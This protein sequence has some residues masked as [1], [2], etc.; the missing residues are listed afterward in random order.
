MSAGFQLSSMGEAFPKDGSW[1]CGLLVNMKSWKV[2]W[3]PAV[4][5]FPQGE[6]MPLWLS[7]LSISVES[8]SEFKEVSPV[9]DEWL[10]RSKDAHVLSL[11]LL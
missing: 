5:Y 10:K 1:K 3:L 6:Q 2:G 8:E 7:I 4:H 11:L 9:G